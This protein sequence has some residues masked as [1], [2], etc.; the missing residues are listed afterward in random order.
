MEAIDNNYLNFKDIGYNFIYRPSQFVSIDRF[1][2]L[3]GDYAVWSLLAHTNRRPMI[4]HADLRLK[5][6]RVIFSQTEKREKEKHG[7]D[8][9]D[10]LT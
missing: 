3:H 4:K 2:C 10:Q 7:K 9:H 8:K 1:F 6:N 5:L